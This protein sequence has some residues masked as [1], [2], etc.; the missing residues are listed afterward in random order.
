[1]P[2]STG[3]VPK[4]E[5]QVVMADRFSF[6]HKRGGNAILLKRRFKSTLLN[7]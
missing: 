1:M 4:N 5:K 7:R 2:Y 6:V 3:T